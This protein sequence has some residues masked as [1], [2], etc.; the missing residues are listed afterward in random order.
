MCVFS[1]RARTEAAVI[2]VSGAAAGTQVIDICSD[3]IKDVPDWI[4]L[5]DRLHSTHSHQNSSAGFARS[6]VP[7]ALA[8]LAWNRAARYGASRIVR[9]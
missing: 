5:L 1:A 3:L 4:S 6:P 8:A 2:P 9:S 7:A